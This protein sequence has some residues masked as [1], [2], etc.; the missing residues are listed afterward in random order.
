M[1]SRVSGDSLRTSYP[2]CMAAHMLAALALLCA[3][4]RALLQPLILLYRKAVEPHAC[5]GDARSPACTTTYA[6]AVSVS[7]L[8]KLLDWTPPT[9]AIAF[10]NEELMLTGPTA[11]QPP[12]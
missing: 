7:V 3:V 9:H 4:V 12:R 10:E 5:H 11:W 6:V 1:T 2:A 8:P